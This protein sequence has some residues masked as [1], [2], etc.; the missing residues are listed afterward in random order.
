MLLF[1]LFLFAVLT[2]SATPTPQS[3]GSNDSLP[4]VNRT[5]CAGK[6]Y[7]YHSLAGYGSLPSD[8]RDKFGDTVSIGSSLDI[9]GWTSPDGGKTYEA[10]AWMLPDRGWCFLRASNPN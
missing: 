2:V 3:D 8:F 6:T 4:I 7:T 5:L 9:T 10:I 1:P